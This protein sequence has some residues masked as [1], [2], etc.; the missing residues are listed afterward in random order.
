[1]NTAI[2]RIGQFAVSIVIA[3]LVSP[4]DFGVFVVALT[5]Y[6]IVVNVSELGVS[7][8]LVREIDNADRIAPT[9][10]TIAIATSGVLATLLFVSAPALASGLGAPAATDAV[11]V[12][13]IPLLL[14]GPTAVPAALLTR[15]FQQGRKLIMDLAAFVVGNGVLVMLALGG[16]GVMALAWSRVA[17]QVTSVG[18][19]FVV[20]KKRYRPG[21]DRREARRLLRFGAPLAGA[22]L[23][24]FGLG[25]IDFLIVGRLAGPVQLG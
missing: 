7:A 18:L 11:R 12:L 14:A 20:T 3:R 2:L 9:V 17:A 25:N 10:S 22:S 1:V 21:F 16:S 15:D 24:G 4:H 23:A 5:I 19:I 6:V 8:A 13:A